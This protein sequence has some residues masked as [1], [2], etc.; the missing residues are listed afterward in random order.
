M[1][2]GGDGTDY[3]YGN[4]SGNCFLDAGSASEPAY[5]YGKDFT[6]Y[7]PVVNGTSYTDI[8]QGQGGTCWI[9]SSLA[10][11]CNR[12]YNLGNNIQYAGNADFRVWLNK[13]DIHGNWYE[14]V[15]FDGTTTSADPVPQGGESWVVIYQ[16]AILEAVGDSVTSPPGG[17]PSTVMPYLTGRTSSL[18]YGNDITDLTIALNSGKLV[19]AATNSPPAGSQY[20]TP[21]MVGNHAYMIEDVRVT[22][23]TTYNSFG[24][25][26]TYASD[27]AVDMYNPWGSNVTVSWSEF[28]SGVHDIDVN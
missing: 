6:A 16:R 2:W 14:D 11:A 5:T 17:N 23:W 26:A 20:V 3:L 8:V 18:Y 22:A 10:A 15:Y 12:G 21:N 7:Y 13:P 24:T 9:L 27:W 4:G 25:T 19:T 1:L 28:S